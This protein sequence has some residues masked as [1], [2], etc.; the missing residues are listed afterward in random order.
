MSLLTLLETQCQNHGP[1][2]FAEYMDTVLYHPTWGYYQ[3][4]T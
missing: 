1:L 3:W 2:T 4:E